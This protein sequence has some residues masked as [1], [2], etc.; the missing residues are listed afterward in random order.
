MLRS[1]VFG[2]LF[3]IA[4]QVAFAQ[5][6]E[7]PVQ[8]RKLD[9]EVEKVLR[10]RLAALR[11]VAELQRELFKVGRIGFVEMNVA[12]RAPFEAELELAA[13]LTERIR[14]REAQ[15]KNAQDLEEITEARADM[16]FGSRLDVK[17]ATAARLRAQ[18][19]LLIE[20]KSAAR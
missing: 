13:S 11:E 19:D 18:A 6:P 10:E 14:I 3:V 9:P 20:K 16:G 17:I 15:L 2:M 7:P 8:S 12:A 1:C 5:Q 4:S